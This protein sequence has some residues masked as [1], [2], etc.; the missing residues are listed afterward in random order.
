M[1]KIRWGILSTGLIAGKMAEALS[2]LDDAEIAAVGSRTQESA[3]A[4]GDE[5]NIPTRHA[6][7]EALAND[8][9]VDVIYI[10]TPHPFHKDNAILCLNGGK[11]VLCEK[12]F[13]I[14]A[15]ELQGVMAVAREKN[16]FLM[17]AMWTRYLPAVVQVREWIAEGLI[18][19]VR[20]VQSNFC[21][22]LDPKPEGRLLNIE[23]GGGALLDLGVYPVSFASMVLGKPTSI[24]SMAHI[25]PTGVDEHVVMSLAYGESK[26]AALSCCLNM[27]APVEA[28]ILGEKGFIKVHED[29]FRAETVT[30]AITGEEP[31]TKHFPHHKNG[32]E[33]E[34]ME[35]MACIRAGKMESDVMTLA[36]SL[37]IMQTMDT[38][39]AQW[40]LKYPTE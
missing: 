30:L 39:R 26:H 20:M 27:N 14:N 34:A 15:Y 18:G 6:S 19:D 36:E 32:Y 1:E 25:G 8:P 17:E 38:M 33:Y 2:S 11:H 23:L 35:V 16:L 40:G 29:F 28:H 37:D 10:G 21:I 9:D 22:D 13:T 5:W 24:Q 7:Y 4:F 3:D 31:K 12:P